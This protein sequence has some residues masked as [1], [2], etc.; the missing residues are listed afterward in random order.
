MASCVNCQQHPVPRSL[1]ICVTLHSLRLCHQAHL[2]INAGHVAKMF[3]DHVIGAA[4][5]KLRTEGTS[6]LLQLLPHLREVTSAMVTAATTAVVRT[7]TLTS[8]PG[9]SCRPVLPAQGLH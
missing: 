8:L 5:V 1:S 2:S 9:S 3:T 4:D 6:A 7:G